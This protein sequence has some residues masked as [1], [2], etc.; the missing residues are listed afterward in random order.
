M[1][2]ALERAAVPARAARAPHP[3]RAGFAVP[4]GSTPATSGASPAGAAPAAALA[5]AGATGSTATPA[6][7]LAAQ[8]AHDV[9]AGL[10]RRRR[11]LPCR[12]LYDER[13]S[14]LFEQILGLPEYYPAEAE[15]AILQQAAEAIALAAGPHA[16][17][18]ELGSGSACKT[19]L[20]LGALDRPAAYVPVDLG[21]AVLAASA[22]Q[23][24]ARF[25]GLPITPLQADFT[26]LAALPRRQGAGPRLLFFA[27][28][29]I[30]NFEPDDA[31]ALLQR[32]ARAAGEGA[33]LVVGVDHTR[34]PALLVPAYDDSAGIT[35]AFNLNLLV[36]INRELQGTFDPAAFR[37]FAQYDP[38]EQRVE[39]HL[40]SRR[41]QRVSV[42]GREFHF[43]AGE[44]IHTE[45]AYK[46]SPFRFVAMAHRAGWKQKQLW[47]HGRSRFAV[48]VLQVAPWA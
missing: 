17:V 15:R 30:G 25:P 40:L 8:F 23:L 22:A 16:T 18:I 37:H 28:C 45:S 38:T 36:R 31:E 5:A 33:L 41:S 4:A 27:G 34:D 12:W 43:A 44:A 47:V 26:R 21:E 14:A 48:H 39:M 7:S 20:L 29:T 42:L 19:P 1:H 3:R 6:P 11:S 24:A 13:G 32:L 2:T 10:A 35:A 46:P 9:L